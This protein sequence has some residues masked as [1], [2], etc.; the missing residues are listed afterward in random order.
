MHL[1]QFVKC[2]YLALYLIQKPIYGYFKLA[3]VRVKRGVQKR[4]STG[5]ILESFIITL[6][7]VLLL[8]LNK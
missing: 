1:F 8:Q 5:N 6:L 2:G 3:Q 4:G 7:L